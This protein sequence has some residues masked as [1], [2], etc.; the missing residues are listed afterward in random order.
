MGP[1]G[2]GKTSLLSCMA[3]IALGGTIKGTLRVNGRVVSPKVLRAISGFVHQDDVIMETMT[4]H[5]GKVFL[6]QVLKMSLKL[7]NPKLDEAEATRR[8]ETTL[9]ELGLSKA[10]NTVI[11]S[12]FVKGVSGG[13][14]KRTA[15]GMELMSQSPVLFLD[16]CTSGLDSFTAYAIMGVLKTIASKGTTVIATLHQPSSEI[17]ELIDDLVI[18]VSGSVLYNGAANQMVEYFADLG[19]K[20]PAYNNP[21]DYIFMQV[22]NN[23]TEEKI[24]E[25]IKKSTILGVKALED[26]ESTFKTSQEP[27][28]FKYFPS[29]FQQIKYLSPRAWKNN[30]RN[31]MM[32]RARLMQSLVI[33]LFIGALFFKIEDS[34]SIS[35]VIQG[36]TGVLFF[37]ATNLFIGGAIATMSMFSTE[38][39][40]F[41]RE[42]SSGYYNVFSYFFAKNIVEFPFQ[43]LF[44]VVFAS[45]AYWMIYFSGD[46]IEYLIFTAACI[47]LNF[48]GISYGIFIGSVFEDINVALS[49]LPVSILPM[50]LM[51]GLLVNADTA[52]A[53]LYW[54]K[55]YL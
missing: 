16:E 23:N 1:S 50:M 54:M 52:P 47:L 17:F 34:G 9:N 19:Y 43:V 14:R 27:L 24:T 53:W 30:L 44:P 29:V 13:E 11:G 48:T 21:P 55:W 37:V 51:G 3:G 18:L 36:T 4:V 15:I 7:R 42:Y 33:S 32:L 10:R 41:I 20:C 2:G 6:T 12:S 49:V 5:E 8:L 39:A 26:A 25:I 28:A 45:I 22:I 38:R 31:P 40:V 35:Q 46:G